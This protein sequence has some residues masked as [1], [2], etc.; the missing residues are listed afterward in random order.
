MIPPLFARARLALMALVALSSLAV[1]PVVAAEDTLPDY[2]IEEFG[3]PPA[4]PTGPLDPAVQTAVQVAFVDS[5]NQGRWGPEQ[6]EALT[7]IV[8][9][10]DPRLVWFI[11]DLMRFITGPQLQIVLAAASSELLETEP[12]RTNDGKSR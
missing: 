6:S 5:M 7:T 4:I 10:G 9:A 3:R 12:P 8:D 11:A 2:V 1:A